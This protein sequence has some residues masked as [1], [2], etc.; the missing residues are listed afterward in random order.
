MKILELSEVCPL[1]TRLSVKVGFRSESGFQLYRLDSWDWV[2]QKKC[3]HISNARLSLLPCQLNSL[4]QICETHVMILTFKVW[5]ILNQRT[6]QIY[7]V[8]MLLCVVQLLSSHGRVS[9]GQTRAHHFSISVFSVVSRGPEVVRTKPTHSLHISY[10]ME[11]PEK[12][13]KRI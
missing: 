1:R 11:K 4:L 7:Y 10:I 2:L 8:T 3:P 5:N 12:V 6:N 9:V 13:R